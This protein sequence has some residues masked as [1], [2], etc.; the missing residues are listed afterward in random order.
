[1]TNENP[2]K[3]LYMD[4]QKYSEFIQIAHSSYI[5]S[6]T[7]GQKESHIADLAIETASFFEAFY[8]IMDAYG[9]VTRTPNFNIRVREDSETKAY[10]DEVMKKVKAQAAEEKKKDKKTKNEKTTKQN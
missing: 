10:W 9:D 5:Q 3:H 6:R 7:Y 2:N 4:A 8:H 1:M